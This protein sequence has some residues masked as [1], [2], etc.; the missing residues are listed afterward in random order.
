MLVE[1]ESMLVTSGWSRLAED[2]DCWKA[3]FALPGN[4]TRI[5][6]RERND[7]LGMMNDE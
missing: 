4:A 3:A 6:E 1:T 2:E 5:P 7:E